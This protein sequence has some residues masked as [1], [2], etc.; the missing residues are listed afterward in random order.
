MQIVEASPTASTL[1]AAR[2]MRLAR[3][4]EASRQYEAK[5]RAE[6]EH[7]ERPVAI[8]V[9]VAVA[10]PIDDAPIFIVRVPARWLD[11]MSMTVRK[12]VSA[13]GREFGV[14]GKD[15]V[16]QSRVV[17]LTVPRHCAIGIA[18]E[19]TG[20]SLPAMGRQFKRDHSTIINSRDRFRKLCE[21]EAFRNRVDQII[22]EI[23][24]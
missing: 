10:E 6:R 19:I 1:A 23:E 21:S 5:K 8:E 22:A 12:C 16:G 2:R 3:I 17:I 4:A 13:M 14:S 7:A 18:I 15:I 24:R 20:M 11:G 9:A